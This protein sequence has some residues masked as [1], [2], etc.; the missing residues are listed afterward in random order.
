VNRLNHLWNTALR[1]DRQIYLRGNNGKYLSYGGG[2]GRG[3]WEK[4]NP[5]FV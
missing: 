4:L 1:T 2:G 5:E 3:D